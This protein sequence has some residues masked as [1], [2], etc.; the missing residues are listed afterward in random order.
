MVKRSLFLQAIRSL[1]FKYKKQLKRT[2]LYRRPSNSGT[3]SER[4]YI[5]RSS[6]LDEE[7]T[8]R[9]LAGLGMP[10][11]EIDLIISGDQGQGAGT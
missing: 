10:E 9:A 8:R 2:E 6:Q 5:P 1:G 4:L 11:S 7:F 3:G